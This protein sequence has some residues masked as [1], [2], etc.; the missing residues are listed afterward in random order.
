MKDELN[1]IKEL[2][3]Q[4]GRSNEIGQAQSL[5]AGLLEEIPS[6]NFE[7]NLKGYRFKYDRNGVR[8]IDLN[9]SS[10]KVIDA[11]LYQRTEELAEELHKKHSFTGI[12]MQLKD[13]YDR[14]GVVDWGELS[15]KKYYL[16][17]NNPINAWEV[18]YNT[19]LQSTSTVYFSTLESAKQAPDYLPKNYPEGFT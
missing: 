7:L 19:L 14:D 12:M 9:D 16:R 1:K 4:A 6:D 17:R 8:Y 2:L 3:E 5:L 10:S 15:L 11:G 13:H 18:A